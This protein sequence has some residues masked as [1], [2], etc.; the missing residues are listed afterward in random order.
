MPHLEPYKH[1]KDSTTHWS[2]GKNQECCWCTGHDCDKTMKIENQVSNLDLSRRLKELGVPQES[3]YSWLIASDGAR[4]MNNPVLDT[5]KYFER[6]SAFTVSELGEMLPAGI[7]GLGITVHQFQEHKL[8]EKTWFIAY[9]DYFSGVVEGEQ[10]DENEANCRAKMLVYL[11]EHSI[12]DVK[13][14]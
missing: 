5:Y 14:L 11:I 8:D 9:T 6:Y 4:L 1:S 7:K 2:C 10:R 13:S 12:I 3:L